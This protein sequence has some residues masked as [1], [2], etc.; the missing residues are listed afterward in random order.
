MSD[1]KKQDDAAT[2]TTQPLPRVD[3]A[4]EMSET[5]LDDVAGGCCYFTVQSM[6]QSS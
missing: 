3:R 4:E 1:D 5:E 2:S 6:A